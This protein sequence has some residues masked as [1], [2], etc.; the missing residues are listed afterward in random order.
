MLFTLVIKL[1]EGCVKGPIKYPESAVCRRR[2]G[3][4]W[5]GGHFGQVTFLAEEEESKSIYF[6]TGGVYKY[7]RLTVSSWVVPRNLPDQG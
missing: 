1:Y 2:G 7:Q 4:K 3:K 6:S 5:P